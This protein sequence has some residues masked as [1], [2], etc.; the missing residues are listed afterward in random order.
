MKKIIFY[1][2]LKGLEKGTT[3]KLKWDRGN[4]TL[5]G[6]VCFEGFRKDCPLLYFEGKT[7]LDIDKIG[8]YNSIISIERIN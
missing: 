3:L 1:E 7:L 2:T 8:S 6:T 4:G 5:E